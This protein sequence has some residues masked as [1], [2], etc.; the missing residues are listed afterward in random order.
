VISAT[1]QEKAMKI[2]QAYKIFEDLLADMEKLRQ[3]QPH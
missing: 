2:Q 1:N 3:E